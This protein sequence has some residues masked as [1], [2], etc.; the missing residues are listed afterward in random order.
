M[1]E[2]KC[3]ALN[4]EPDKDGAVPK[5]VRDDQG[6]EPFG[7]EAVCEAPDEAG[8]CC[9]HDEHEVELGQM[10]KTVHKSGDYESDIRVPMCGKSFLDVSSPEDLLCRTD[11]EQHQKGEYQRILAILHAIDGVHLRTG[12]VEHE[13]GQAVA[14]PE[15]SPHRRSESHTDQYVRKAEMHVFPPSGRGPCGIK[16][17]SGA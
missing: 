1:V 3:E 13:G 12:E 5:G 4:R 7:E 8:Y 14:D 11:D 10:H 17:E 16:G 2:K 15:D 6:S 9:G